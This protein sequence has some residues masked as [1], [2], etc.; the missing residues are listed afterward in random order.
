MEGV[1]SQS[2][3]NLPGWVP[4]AAEN[5]LCHTVL[6]QSIR[7][8]AKKNSCHPSTILRQVRRLEAKRDDPLIDAALNSFAHGKKITPQAKQETRMQAEISLTQRTSPML[9]AVGETGGNNPEIKNVL[10]CICEKNAILAVARNMDTAVVVRDDESGN[11]IRTAVVTSELAQEIAMRGWISCKDPE[12]KIARYVATS[13]GRR[14]LREMIAT[15][16]NKAQGLLADDG[17]DTPWDAKP[18][19][20]KT[21]RFVTAESPLIGLSRRRDRDGQAFLSKEQVDVGERLRQDFELSNLELVEES[22]VLS[23]LA[24][25]DETLPAAILDARKRL[26]DALL[27][28]GPGLADICLQCCCLLN[29]LESTE[30][31]MG[32]SSRS[33]KIVLR[34]ALT[35]L[36]QHYKATMG[37]FEPMI[38]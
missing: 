38:G 15:D 25:V 7:S 13:S 21:S 28:L 22:N 26:H 36:I 4:P 32:W 5:Y 35:R 2:D 24:E 20:R 17:E 6:G 1:S 8:V 33:G 23:L 12:A 14:A 11:S 19:R 9:P 10:R 27:E 34:I 31:K 29:G 30:K 18:S 3:L 37:R 16:E